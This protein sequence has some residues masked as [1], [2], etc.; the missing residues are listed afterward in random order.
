[1]HPYSEYIQDY[2]YAQNNLDENGK[3]KNDFRVTSWGRVFRKIWLDELPQLVNFVRGDLNLMGVRALSRHYFSLYPK[4][5][6]ELRIRFKPGLVPPYYAD[7]PKTFEEIVES[8]RRYL[9][10]KLQHSLR[11]D[12]IYFFRAWNNIVF[13]RARSQ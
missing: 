3:I 12:V 7:L 4:D 2:V 1:M 6:Q 5:L 8:E 10:S 11:T 9:Q 13:K